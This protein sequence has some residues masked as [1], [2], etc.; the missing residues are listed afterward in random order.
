VKR[1]TLI[2]R[3]SIL[4]VIVM[5]V[6]FLALAPR[7]AA[8]AGTPPATPTASPTNSSD[9]ILAQ[10]RAADA[11]ALK[12]SA[13]ASNAIGVVNAMLAFVQVAAIVLGAVV[14]ITG[15]SLTAAAIRLIQNY[16]N[17]LDG[18]TQKM[19]DMQARLRTQEEQIRGKAES[20][21]R[22]LTL[23]QLGEHQLSDRNMNAALRTYKE[24]YDL[25][26]DNRATN[27]F[28]GY[29]YS[30][31]KNVEDG[32]RHLELALRDDYVYPPAEAAL[33]YALRLK[34]EKEPDEMRQKRGYAEAEQLFLKALQD[35]HQV[36]DITGESI[37]A[38]L[39]GLYK[40]QGRTAEAI[41]AYLAAVKVTPENSYPVV[42]LAMLHFMEGNI[43]LAE[44][45][46]KRSVVISNRKLDGDP[47]DFWSCFDLAI[48]QIVLGETE[49]AITQVLLAE[50]SLQGVYPLEIF[51]RDL[52]RLGN[53]PQPP[54]DL[55]KIQ[56]QV[57]KA[58][59]RV[60]AQ[61]E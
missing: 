50:Q 25:D 20:A 7:V 15:F 32:I 18:A 35:D 41:E 16:R 43:Q 47:F 52:E 17:Q 56:E 23:L 60:K 30:Q 45:Y 3:L 8:Q 6:M 33:G 49:D 5:G 24:A 19:E 4:A 9:D 12:A 11:D 31:Q 26:P 2:A 37:W 1:T 10:A 57:E 39:G 53:A 14:T 54:V 55:A 13:D 61:A 38:V 51:Q 46:F 48:A 34:A 44:K 42:N 29:I 27:Y 36:R 22:A 28:L 59:I 21:V 58:I 40:K